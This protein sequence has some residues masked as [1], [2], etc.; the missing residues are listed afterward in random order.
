MV[1]IRLSRTGKANTPSYRVVITPQ[2][3]KRDSKFI[4]L[5]GHYSPKTK[6]LA[7]KE[8]RAK[9]WLS[10]GAQPTPTVKTLLARLKIIEFKQE[11]TFKKNP[12]KK[13]KDR[14]PEEKAAEAPAA[15]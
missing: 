10:V 5:I 12:G 1:R 7:I 4:E 15:Q 8:D 9:Y 2:R 3:E 11:P 13:A 6:E 14:A